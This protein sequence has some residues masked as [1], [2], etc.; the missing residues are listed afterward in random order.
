MEYNINLL[1]RENRKIT[2]IPEEATLT[3]FKK[4][5]ISSKIIFSRKITG[6]KARAY[7][8]VLY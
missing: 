6:D 8:S 4:S 3:L 2:L 5:F 1:L 7:F